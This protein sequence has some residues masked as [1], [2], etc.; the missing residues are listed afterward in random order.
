MLNIIVK[1]K[2]NCY[3]AVFS[4]DKISNVTKFHYNISCRLARLAPWLIRPCVYQC[5]SL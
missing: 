5:S 4:D 3:I 2:L 1:L